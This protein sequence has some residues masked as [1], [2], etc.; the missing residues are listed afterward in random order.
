M[1]NASYVRGKR[2]P[3]YGCARTPNPAMLC[4]VAPIVGR[5]SFA[6]IVRGK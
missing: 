2:L 6:G 4:P 5:Q 3:R 1:N